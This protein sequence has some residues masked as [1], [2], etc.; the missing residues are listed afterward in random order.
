MADITPHAGFVDGKGEGF[1]VPSAGV[2]L[3]GRLN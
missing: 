3:G 1:G 2:P